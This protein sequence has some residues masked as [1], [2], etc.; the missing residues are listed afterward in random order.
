MNTFSPLDLVRAHRWSNAFFTT[1]A[2]SLSCFEA[3]ILDALVRQEVER[4]LV[5]ADV[6]GVGAAVAEYGSR[7]A[8]RMYEIEPAVVEHGCFHPKFAALTSSTEA[9]LVIGSGNLTFRRWGS[10]LECL[11]HLHANFAA[12]KLRPA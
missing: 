1:Y 10:N 4:T 2:L 6:A 9:C 5:L 7:C 12:E 11:E 8:G 3:V